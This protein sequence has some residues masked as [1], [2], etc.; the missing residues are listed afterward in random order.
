MKKQEHI[1]KM[2]QEIRSSLD[3][4]KAMEVPLFDEYSI[5]GTYEEYICCAH[6][7]YG[8]D[9]N[10]NVCMELYEL[11]PNMVGLKCRVSRRDGCS[12][13][14]SCIRG[15]KN[16]IEKGVAVLDKMIIANIKQVSDIEF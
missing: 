10:V 12:Y 3:C 13:A 16:D 9:V 2:V 6:H 5:Q 8:D 1:D 7:M 4:V 15:S 11:L 14:V